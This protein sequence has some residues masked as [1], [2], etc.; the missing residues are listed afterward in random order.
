MAMDIRSE[1]VLCIAARLEAKLKAFG[2][3]DSVVELCWS[4]AVEALSVAVG[5]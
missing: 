1:A 3:V 2:I 4:D 5:W